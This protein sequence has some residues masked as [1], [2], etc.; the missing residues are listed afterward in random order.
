MASFAFALLVRV[1]WYRGNLLLARS[2]HGCHGCQAQA[3]QGPT[4]LMRHPHMVSASSD[5]KKKARSARVSRREAACALA[6]LDRIFPDWPLRVVIAGDSVRALF[7]SKKQRGAGGRRT[8]VPR[9][10][11]R[12]EEYWSRSVARIAEILNFAN[13]TLIRTSQPV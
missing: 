4:A 3:H 10:K 8:L 2:S 5:A 7:R 9:S 1:L 12:V 13:L 6:V 11:S